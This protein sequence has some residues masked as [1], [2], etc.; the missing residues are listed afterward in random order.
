MVVRA[1]PGIPLGVLL[2]VATGIGAALNSLVFLVVGLFV[3]STAFSLGFCLVLGGLWMYSLRARLHEAWVRRELPWSVRDLPGV[4][5]YVLSLGTFTAMAAAMSWPLPGDITTA[6]GPLVTLILADGRLPLSLQGYVILYPPGLHVLAASLGPLAVTFGGEMVFALGAVLAALLAPLMYAVTFQFTRSWKWGAV[7]A[8]I[9]FIPHP[10]L[11][12]EQWTVGYFL[13]GPYSNLFGFVVVLA[14]L[15]TM[16]LEQR[17]GTCLAH[18]HRLELAV[19]VDLAALFIYP[20]F[21]L[22]STFLLALWLVA[23]RAAIWAEVRGLIAPGRARTRAGAVVLAVGLAVAAYVLLL[24]LAGQTPAVLWDYLDGRFVP[25]GAAPISA[26][27]AYALN[28]LFLVDHVNG[29]AALAA[30]G[31][32]AFQIW[33]RRGDVFDVFYLGLGAA[34]LVSIPPPGYSVLWLLFP[35]RTAPLFVL[36]AWPGL[37]RAVE[38]FRSR[39]PAPAEP[40]EPQERP[41]R[42]RPFRAGVV[43]AGVAALTLVLPL[44]AAPQIVEPM[45]NPVPYWDWFS[46]APTFDQDF[47]LLVWTAE[48]ANRSRLLLNDGSYMSRDLSSLSAQNMSNTIWYEARFPQRAKDLEVVWSQPRNIAYLSRMITQYGVS[49]ILSTSEWGTIFLW[50]GSTYGGK[51]YPPSM[52]ASIFDHY[53][54]LSIDYAQQTNRLYDVQSAPSITRVASIAN[55]TPASFWT[56]VSLS[57]TGTIGAPLIDSTG[58]VHVENGSNKV[59]ELDHTFG[60]PQNWSRIAYLSADIW[61]SRSYGLT[62]KVQDSSGNAMYW[63]MVTLAGKT[64]RVDLPLAWPDRG[65]ADVTSH[66]ISV[67]GVIG[68]LVAPLMEAGDT[69]SVTNVTLSS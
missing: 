39:A 11:N 1:K 25:E 28:P 41:T 15:G 5:I 32:A 43:F 47:Q 9:P 49:Y 44:V 65:A 24:A 7:A 52:I 18:L 12:L 38:R 27:L 31:L 3:V 46:L 20:P 6:H 48:H 23:H 16:G 26:P 19:A 34:L 60:T 61:A 68:G 33:R 59:L 29:W 54:F 17:P 62:I 58:V 21:F 64:E 13:N 35:S 30:V 53:P 56:G 45:V 2:P 42:D 67:F 63:D 8:A 66:T 69:L 22:V 4:A 37:F 36:L 55:T 14:L 40:A 57:A 50:E 10:S 51:V